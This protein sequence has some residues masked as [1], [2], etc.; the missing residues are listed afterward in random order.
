MVIINGAMKKVRGFEA[1]LSVDKE[2]KVDLI[3]ESF[4]LWLKS[5]KMG[6]KSLP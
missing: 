4:S 2:L 5:P 6:V 1:T 3:S